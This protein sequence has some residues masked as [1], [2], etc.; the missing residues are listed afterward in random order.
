MTAMPRSP[1]LRLGRQSWV[2]AHRWA[3]LTITLFLVVAGSTGAL[4]PWNAELT[5]AGRPTLA[6]VTPPHPGARVLDAVTLAERVERATG[7]RVGDIDFDVPS[8]HVASLYVGPRGTERLAY[9]TVWADPYT[10]AVRLT[11]R[12]GR[13]ADGP[14]AIMS[15]L[16]TLHM[17]LALGR[18]GQLALGIAALIWTVDCFVGVYLTLPIRRETIPGKPASAPGWWTRWRPAWLVRWRRGPHRLTFDLHRA[19]GLWVWPLLFAFA[20]SAV[21]FNL[22]EVSTPVMRAFGAADRFEPPAAA[23]PL[24]VPPI[25]L[26]QAQARGDALLR[27]VGAREGFS[28]GA[29]SGMSYD[30]ARAAY[31]YTARSTLDVVSRGGRTAVSFSAIDGRLLKFDPPIA[32][33]PADAFMT[34]LNLLH[35]AQI[36]GLPYRVFVSLMGVLVVTLSVTG[37]LIWMKKRSARLMKGRRG[38]K[39]GLVRPARAAAPAG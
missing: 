6:A 9:D 36:L 20:W 27:E 25:G 29:P 12:Y 2:V 5:L 37:V 10:G 23:A 24:P 16:Y 28:V 15:F 21:G 35:L 31:R 4:L 14:Q 17:E 11:W 18:F 8:D 32:P 13:L 34:W 39:P 22:S 38:A 1:G 19:G 33:S 30:A 26:R 7:A 3:G